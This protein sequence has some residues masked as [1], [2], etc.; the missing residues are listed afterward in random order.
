MSYQTVNYQTAVDLAVMKGHWAIRILEDLSPEQRTTK[1]EE[2]FLQA[3]SGQ[4]EETATLYFSFLLQSVSDCEL[5]P[6]ISEE[7]GKTVLQYAPESRDEFEKARANACRMGSLKTMDLYGKLSG[8][9]KITVEKRGLESL[10][11]GTKKTMLAVVAT[12][13]R[14]TKDEKEADNCFNFL[15]KVIKS[16]GYSDEEKLQQEVLRGATDTG[17]PAN[18]LLRHFVQLVPYGVCDYNLDHKIRKV[19]SILLIAWS[20]N[21]DLSRSSRALRA[22]QLLLELKET[23][24]FQTFATFDLLRRVSAEIAAFDTAIYELLEVFKKGV[25]N[26]PGEKSVSYPN[27]SRAEILITVSVHISN[28]HKGELEKDGHK[29]FEKAREHALAWRKKYRKYSVNLK[30][31]VVGWYSTEPKFERKEEFN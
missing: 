13:W 8:L 11:L 12:Q 9:K 1:M 2:F 7:R 29:W 31:V 17:F 26:V 21:C 3:V 19:A 20:R 14:E 23:R 30:L 16:A 4:D 28:Y 10:R 15:M 22:C 27:A 24:E 25:D 6:F 5:A 18:R